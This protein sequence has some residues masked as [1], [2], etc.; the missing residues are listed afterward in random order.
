MTDHTDPDTH[1]VYADATAM[2]GSGSAMIELEHVDKFFGDFQ[3]LADINLKVA[4]QEVVVVI[5]PSGSGKSTMIRCINRLEEHDR[6]RIVVDGTEVSDDQLRAPTAASTVEAD[7][8]IRTAS[9]T[10]QR[11]VPFCPA[12]SRIASTAGPPARSCA[13]STSAV[14]ST[15]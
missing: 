8:P 1:S 14:I 11:P 15:R 13:A 2:R 9:I 3:A 10:V 12:L 7:C 5:G 6:G 4:S